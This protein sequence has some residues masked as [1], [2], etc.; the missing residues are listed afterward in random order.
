MSH[1]P[2]AGTTVKWTG[3]TTRGFSSTTGFGATFALEVRTART[4][5]IGAATAQR[6]AAAGHDLVLGFRSDSAPAR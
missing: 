5:G 4:R 3:Q 1:T 6:L 2:L